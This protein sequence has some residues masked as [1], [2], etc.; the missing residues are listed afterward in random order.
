MGLYD[1]IADSVRPFGGFLRCETC[2][3]RQELGDI[4]HKFQHG[5]PKCCGYTMHWWTQRQ[6]AAGEHLED[7]PQMAQ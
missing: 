4:A 6:V 3:C 7:K 5:W 2:D 1:S